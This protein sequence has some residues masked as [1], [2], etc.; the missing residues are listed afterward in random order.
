MFYCNSVRTEI[1]L[2]VLFE[3]CRTEIVSLVCFIASVRTEIVSLMT[4]V[5][6]C[7]CVKTEIVSLVCFIAMV[8]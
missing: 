3:Q 8:L 1:V 4:Y 7:N 6:Y 5:F 2:C